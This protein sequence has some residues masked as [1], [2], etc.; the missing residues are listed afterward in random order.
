MKAAVYSELEISANNRVEVLDKRPHGN[1][2][3]Y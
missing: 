2:M 3:C 1:T